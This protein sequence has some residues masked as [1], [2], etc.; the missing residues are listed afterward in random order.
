M[1]SIWKPGQILLKPNTFSGTTIAM[2]DYALEDYVTELNVASAQIARKAADDYTAK[3]PSK[4]RF[5]AGSI[6]P[7]NKTASMSPDVSDPGYRAITFDEL[8]VAL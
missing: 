8:R 5:V 1:P 6:G 2:T 3:N 7:T 4:P